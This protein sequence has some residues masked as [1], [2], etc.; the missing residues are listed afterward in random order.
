MV[1]YK[2]LGFYGHEQEQEEKILMPTS[3]QQ[4]IR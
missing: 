2:K 1:S 4:H 3:S